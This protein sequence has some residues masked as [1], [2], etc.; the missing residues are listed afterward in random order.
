MRSTAPSPA[1]W[2]LHPHNELRLQVDPPLQPLVTR[3]LPRSARPLDQTHDA[4]AAPGST[5]LLLR[6]W[7]GAPEDLP[8]GQPTLRLGGVSAWVDG[9]AGRASLR[10]EDARGGGE[11]DL[12]SGVADLHAPASPLPTPQDELVAFTLLTISAA[13]LL[14]RGGR[15]LAHAAA[16]A[17][18]FGGAWLLVGDARAGKTTTTVNLTGQGCA[19]LSDDH[20]VLSAADGGGVRVDGLPRTFHLDAGWARGEVEGTRLD[21]DPGEIDG[22]RWMPSA[23]LSGLLFPVVEADSATALQPVSAADA[24]AGLVRQSP[25]FLADTVAAPGVLALLERVVQRPAFRLVLGIDSYREPALLRERLTPL[26][27]RPG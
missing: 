14:S 26:F 25:W 2:A 13:L 24:L 21:F 11:V 4:G 15:A 22:G 10:A 12:E 5:R 16:V 9:A 23:P 20:V 1:V 8:P 17:D 7:D 19:Y 6:E 18:P 3:W 27:C